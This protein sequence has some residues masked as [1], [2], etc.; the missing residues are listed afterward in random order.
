MLV[1]SVAWTA[2]ALVRQPKS[3]ERRRA[4]ASAVRWSYELGSQVSRIASVVFL[5][6]AC[7]EGRAH[8]LNVVLLTYGLVLGF[9]RLVDNLYWRHVALH[10]VNCIFTAELFLLGAARFL[11]CIVVGARC[12]GDA[13][14]VGGIASLAAAFQS[15]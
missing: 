3:R 2:T 12:A 11:P 5:T 9:T 6:L 1:L 8:L 7:V 15:T 10:Q 4:K 13:S 14:L